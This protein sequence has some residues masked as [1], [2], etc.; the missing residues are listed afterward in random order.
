MGTEIDEKYTY[1]ENSEKFR[2]KLPHQQRFSKEEIE[3]ILLG[4]DLTTAQFEDFVDSINDW[5][6]FDKLIDMSLNTPSLKNKK[7]GS[8]PVK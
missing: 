1:W 4:S 2:F 7:G 3:V 5:D 8:D 6:F